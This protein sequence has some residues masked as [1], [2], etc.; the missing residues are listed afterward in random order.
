[1]MLPRVMPSLLLRNKGLV[2]GI[3]FKD[4]R[5]VGDPLNAVRIF[6]EKE[7]DELFFLDITASSE[8]RS[9]DLEYVQNIADECY[10]P[11]GVG[12]GIKNLDE[13]RELVKAGA[14]KIA[15]NTSAVE[16]P[17]LIKKGAEVFGS[18]CVVV[19]IDTKKTW[20][21]S[22]RVYIRSGAEKTSLEPVAWAQEV[23]QHGAGEILINSIDQ[24]GSMQGYDLEIIK[25]VSASV[26]IPVIACGGA[27]KN[28]HFAEAVQAG[29][30]A[31]AAGSLF[32]FHGRR[33]AVLINAPTTQELEHVF[34]VHEFQ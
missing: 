10:M 1:M 13:F 6:N 5:Y 8:G 25:K 32:V 4:Y 34:K 9:I 26:T 19:S 7:V 23:E 11:F 28:V 29:A 33:R 22:Y 14:E 20:S 30:S 12:G 27:G 3:G 16:N 24:D 21:G 15:I 2:K 31:V 17:Q 18:Q